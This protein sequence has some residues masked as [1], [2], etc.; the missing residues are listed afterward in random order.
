MAVWN[1]SWQITYYDAEPQ[2][3]VRESERR[4]NFKI[5]VPHRTIG[6]YTRTG[7]LQRNPATNSAAT[8]SASRSSS[9]RSSTSL[10][11]PGAHVVCTTHRCFPNRRGIPLGPAVRVR[12]DW[13]GLPLAGHDYTFWS[14]EPITGVWPGDDYHHELEFYDSDEETPEPQVRFRLAVFAITPERA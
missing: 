7:L 6:Q 1:N 3:G 11:S 5:T 12:A 14:T 4:Y 10:R 8:A 2:D 9:S 13:D